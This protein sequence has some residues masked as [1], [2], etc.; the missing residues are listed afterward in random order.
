MS[1]RLLPED[2]PALDGIRF[3]ST[4]SHY[5][6]TVDT[7]ST[8]DGEQHTVSTVLTR[9][10]YDADGELALRPVNPDGP[11]GGDWGYSHVATLPETAWERFEESVRQGRDRSRARLGAPP[12]YGTPGVEVDRPQFHTVWPPADALSLLAVRDAQD[13]RVGQVRITWIPGRP[14]PVVQGSPEWVLGMLPAVEQLTDPQT[15]KALVE[16]WGWARVHTSGPWPEPPN[17]S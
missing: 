14:V 10:V 5:W 11:P 8:P 1:M 17:R 16:G 2:R 4:E 7:W 15:V 6:G 13:S 12:I 9:Y 3:V